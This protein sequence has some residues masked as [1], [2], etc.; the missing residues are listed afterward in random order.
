MNRSGEGGEQGNTS[1]KHNRKLH[2]GTGA[3]NNSQG[4]PITPMHTL[5]SL[6]VA[7][8]KLPHQRFLLQPRQVTVDPLL[9]NILHLAAEYLHG[10]LHAP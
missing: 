9:F 3:G 4:Q 1:M 8:L 6:A 10:F 7:H 5:R 2:R